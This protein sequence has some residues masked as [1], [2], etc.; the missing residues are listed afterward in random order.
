[1]ES[2]VWYQQ[3]DSN[4]ALPG[5]DGAYGFGLSAPNT[6]GW[7][8]G[9]SYKRI[10]DN[11]NPALGFVNQRGIEDHALDFGFRRFLTPGGYLRSWYG[12]FDSYRNTST[13]TGDLVSQIMDVRM[14]VNNNTNDVVSAALVE[15]REVLNRNFT[16][17]RA[18]DGS[19]SVVLPP[20]DYSFTSASASLST[21]GQREWAARLSV[22]AGDYYEG[23]NFQRS[24]GITWQ[25]PGYNLQLSY[26]ENEIQLPQGDFTVRQITFNTLVNFT[27][28]LT[29]TNRI[30]YD[31]VSEGLGL[32]S[33][34][35]WLPEA[36]REAYIVM[37]WGMIDPDKNNDF[38][39]TNND[40]TVKYNYT[41]R[42]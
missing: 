41:F 4:T 25:R 21:G 22:S 3:S 38:A 18:P 10:Q 17:Y 12:G 7:R 16:I 30:Q 34:L 11:F 20:G 19:R 39:S 31:N 26:S 33:R 8:G 28:F 29:W 9:Y 37:N 6:N 27:P 23:E 40:L 14:N 32:N 5:D 2:E 13:V 24:A 35:S 42:F 1:V 15:Q 36:G